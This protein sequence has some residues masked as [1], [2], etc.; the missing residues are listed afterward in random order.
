MLNRNFQT[1]SSNLIMTD[2]S[3]IKSQAWELRTTMMTEM[4]QNARHTSHCKI[5]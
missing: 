3:T 1:A 5:V 4:P 2:N